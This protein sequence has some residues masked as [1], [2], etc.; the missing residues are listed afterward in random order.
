MIDLNLNTGG[1]RLKFSYAVANID[2]GYIRGK[3][4][5]DF[6]DSTVSFPIRLDNNVIIVELKTDNKFIRNADGVIRARLEIIAGKD[7]FLVPWNGEVKIEK[8]I[9]EEKTLTNDIVENETEDGVLLEERMSR[10][11]KLVNK[12]N[13]VSTE[14]NN[15]ND[16]NQKE[17]NDDIF[18]D[19][20][21]TPVEEIIYTKDELTE[22]KEVNERFSDM[23][24][25]SMDDLI[26]KMGDKN[27]I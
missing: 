7:T 24:N 26:K 17:E 16:E 10:L 11:R 4:V 9:Q 21:N 23:L 1:K 2:P 25:I 8:R 12:E 6:D 13:I 15:F 14:K 22:R 20:I 19:F 3:F 18:D 27:E 5:M